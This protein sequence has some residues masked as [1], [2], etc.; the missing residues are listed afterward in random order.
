MI[1]SMYVAAILGPLG[2]WAAAR[3]TGKSTGVQAAII[4]CLC[5]VWLVLGMGFAQEFLFLTLFETVL[6]TFAF[7]GVVALA[8]IASIGFWIAI[9]SWP[10]RR[11]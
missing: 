11:L 8:A 6:E 5:T 7:L 1:V 4:F 10:D 3:R 9:S 2:V